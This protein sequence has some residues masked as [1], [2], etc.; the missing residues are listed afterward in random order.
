MP[1]RALPLS[2]ATPIASTGIEGETTRAV[3]PAITPSTTS[4]ST[5]SP[6]LS[7]VARTT[8]GSQTPV[9]A[10]KS[11]TEK[12]G[13]EKSSTDKPSTDNSSADKPS[14]EKPGTD[15]ASTSLAKT[16]SVNA[17]KTAS[18]VEPVDKQASERLIEGLVTTPSLL[19]ATEPAIPSEETVTKSTPPRLADKPLKIDSALTKATPSKPE[20][21]TLSD[22]NPLA[23]KRPVV[24]A[25]NVA[26]PEVTD[27]ASVVVPSSHEVDETSRQTAEYAKMAA[28]MQQAVKQKFPTVRVKVTC[29]EDG[30]IVDG[31][32][33][34]NSEASK[35][36]SFI[37]KTS[38][39]P[40]ADRLTTSQ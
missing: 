25:A 32:L 16:D 12:S 17:D 13:L 33:L 8:P 20:R 4:S 22:F 31:N 39:C 37:R 23:M 29:N 38:L 24:K 26:I 15:K 11:S 21:V 34:N 40:V 1:P 3:G 9:V 2:S 6:T 5:A 28:K 36:L 18:Q 35:V 30:L 10:H 27:P 14:A 7:T 19:V